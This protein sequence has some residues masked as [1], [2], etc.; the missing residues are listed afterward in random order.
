A[1]IYQHL[2]RI[3]G[4]AGA[5]IDD[6]VQITQWFVTDD[7]WRTRTEWSGLSITRYLEERN[8]NITGDR[9]ASVGM[10]IHGLALPDA[11][12]A[13]DALGVR[14]AGEKKQGIFPTTEKH[15]VLAGYSPAIKLGDWVFCSGEVATDW[16]GDWLSSV[17]MGKPSS[18]APE[19]RVNAYHWLDYPV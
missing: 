2:H 4:Q 14:G 19:A 12:L 6:V 8:R 1:V 11:G 3:L 15:K 10:G 7:A 5:A 18:V 9:P 17:H 13:V 16:K